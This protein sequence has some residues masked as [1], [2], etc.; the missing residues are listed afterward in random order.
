MWGCGNVG[1]CR[2]NCRRRVDIH[3]NSGNKSVLLHLIIREADDAFLFSVN[4]TY[5]IGVGKSS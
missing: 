1:M 3:E 2:L 4:V 5:K